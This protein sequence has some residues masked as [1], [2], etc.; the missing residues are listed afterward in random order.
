MKTAEFFVF[1][2][3]ITISFVCVEFVSGF[4]NVDMIA[5]DFVFIAYLILIQ[6][7]VCFSCWRRFPRTWFPFS[8][9]FLTMISTVAS[10]LSFA[11]VYMLGLMTEK[12]NQVHNIVFLVFSACQ[13]WFLSVNIGYEI[14]IEIFL[15]KRK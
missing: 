8:V 7:N 1:H 13:L 3:F 6:A 4:S 10:T 15:A 11:S 2:S 9:Y 12:G 14:E 5:N